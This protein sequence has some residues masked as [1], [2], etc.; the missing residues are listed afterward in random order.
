MKFQQLMNV[1]NNPIE[2]LPPDIEKSI[3]EVPRNFRMIVWGSSGNGKTNFV[4]K[5]VDA[6]VGKGRILYLSLEEGL[7]VSFQNSIK[8]NASKDW[9]A[10]DFV[11]HTED[12]QKLVSRLKRRRSA[13]FVIVD[14]LQYFNITID[15]YKQICRK[16]P[17]KAFVFI[18]HADGKNPKGSV[19]DYIRYDAG[20][21]VY[22]S[23][24]VA[25]ATSRY[26][27]NNPYVVW[28]E[29]ARRFWGDKYEKTTKG[30]AAKPKKAPAKQKPKP[31]ADEKI[32]FDQPQL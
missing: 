13:E 29:G 15:Q 17:D 26:G 5:L 31:Q 9:T 24:H 16:F 28:E 3:G 21:K 10:I 22:V 7:D 30:L 8:R 11:D 14:S 27:G 12:Y 6:L 20:V 23:G 4:V 32:P 1:K 19:G 25:F 2:G 18:S